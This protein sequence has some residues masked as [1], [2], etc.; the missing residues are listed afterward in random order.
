MRRTYKVYVVGGDN[1]VVTMFRKNGW[2][3]MDQM[4]YADL[5][6]FTGGCD[7]SPVLYGQQKHSRT[8]D[9]NPIRDK[10]EA[11]IFNLCLH[12]KMYMAGICRGLQLINIMSGGSMWQDVDNHMGNHKVQCDFYNFNYTSNSIHHQQIIPT[13]RAW[14]LGR[15]SQCAKKEKMDENGRLDIFRPERAIDPEVVY[16][17]HIKS[18]G[19]QWHPEYFCSK[20]HDLDE[21]YINYLH[22]VL[23]S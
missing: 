12:N 3:V 4:R 18:F 11:I 6:Q 9:M 21:I 7:I 14:V 16:F 22:D 2:E 1:D 13:P 19:V 8:S 23:L 5:I 20:Q 17:E 10:K 15:T